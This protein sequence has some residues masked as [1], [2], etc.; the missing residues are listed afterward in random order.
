MAIN[1]I[2]PG[3]R[4]SKAVVHAGTVYLAGQVADD[5]KADISTQTQQVLDKID[6]Y[7]RQAG[8]GKSNLLSATIYIT[9]MRNFQAMNAV[10]DAW[11]DKENTPARA[12]VE[13]RLAN[14]ELLVEIMAI[15][16][17]P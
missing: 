13:A 10:W 12:T 9:D 5:P 6:G 2:E 8:T 3:S 11:V 14:S 4:M 16:A 1:R 17:L 7:L 15:A